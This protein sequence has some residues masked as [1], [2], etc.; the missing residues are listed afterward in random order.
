MRVRSGIPG[1]GEACV[2]AGIPSRPQQREGECQE[3]AVANAAA[4]Q[5]SSRRGLSRPLRVLWPFVP[6]SSRGATPAQTPLVQPSPGCRP[7]ARQQD[8]SPRAGRRGRAGRRDYSSQ[9]RAAVTSCAVARRSHAL[10]GP[11]VLSGAGSATGGCGEARAHR[12]TPHRSP[13]DPPRGGSSRGAQR[14]GARSRL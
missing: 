10:A 14:G 1:T 5:P 3:L 4:F 11:F 9:G 8:P 12:T 7:A 2:C 13:P 6:G